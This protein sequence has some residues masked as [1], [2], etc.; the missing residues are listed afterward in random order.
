[1]PRYHTLQVQA[2][3]DGFWTGYIH[4]RGHHQDL[5][6]NYTPAELSDYGKGYRL[7]YCFGVQHQGGLNGTVTT[8]QHFRAA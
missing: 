3:N 1:M 7:G 2:F 6:A 4:G 5:S 8:V